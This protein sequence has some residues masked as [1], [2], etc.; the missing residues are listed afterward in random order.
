MHSYTRTQGIMAVV[1]GAILVA[2]LWLFIMVGHWEEA[3]IDSPH[4]I[5]ALSS[6]SQTK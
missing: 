2:C 5:P 6:Q 4:A 3:Q 1:V